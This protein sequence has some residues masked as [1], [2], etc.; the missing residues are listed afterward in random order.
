MVFFQASVE[1][2]IPTSSELHASTMLFC[3]TNHWN[4]FDNEQNLSNRPF[5]FGK[6]GTEHMG[7]TCCI[8]FAGEILPGFLS[9]SSPAMRRRDGKLHL[10][11]PYVG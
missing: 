9:L 4:P 11:D 5:L 7:K 8:R 3:E 10:S 2:S 6:D 1:I